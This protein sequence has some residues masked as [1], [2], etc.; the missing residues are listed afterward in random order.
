[1]NRKKLSA[2][3]FAALALGAALAVVFLATRAEAAPLAKLKDSDKAKLF[4]ARPFTEAKLTDN[5]R[6]TTKSKI[7]PK[8]L[9][10]PPDLAVT[11]FMGAVRG[12]Q[13]VLGGKVQNVGTSAYNGSRTIR[14][15][16]ITKSGGANLLREVNVP[17]LKKGATW[18][19]PMF[20]IPAN[21]VQ[22]MQFVLILSYNGS[23]PADQN[24]A[25]TQ[26]DWKQ[27]FVSEIR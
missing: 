20:S 23:G 14:L 22:T 24:D 15:F 10:L 6:V 26:N 3:A 27:T 17:A 18:S 7:D 8:L 19:T 21:S 13:Y 1:M 12:N 5:S 9:I 4:Q 2:R 25:N 16:T 11:E